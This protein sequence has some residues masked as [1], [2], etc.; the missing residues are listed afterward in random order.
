[1]R[2]C[3]RAEILGDLTWTDLHLLRSEGQLFSDNPR[4]WQLTR[5]IRTEPSGVGAH[6][7]AYAIRDERCHET[8]IETTR[9]EAPYRNIRHQPIIGCPIEFEAK[10]QLVRSIV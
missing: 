8:R 2:P 1:M 6:F 10:F 3:H 9:K 7:C 4:R 5:E